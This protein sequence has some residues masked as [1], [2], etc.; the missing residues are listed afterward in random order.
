MTLIQIEI[1]WDKPNHWIIRIEEN[2]GYLYCTIID[3]K[4]YIKEI[5]VSPIHRRKGL[6]TLLIKSAGKIAIKLGLQFVSLDNVL[7]Q[8]NLFYENLGFRFT[9]EKDHIALDSDM[10]VKTKV[11]C[12]LAKAKCLVK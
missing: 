4:L 3:D 6:G 7:P 8:N 10:R 2:M 11:L 9:E 5:E 1:L 12:R